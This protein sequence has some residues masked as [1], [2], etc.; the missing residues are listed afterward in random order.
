MFKFLL[1][2]FVDIV[3]PVIFSTQ[4]ACDVMS[5]KYVVQQFLHSLQKNLFSSINDFF[6]RPWFLLEKIRAMSMCILITKL[7]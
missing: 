1:T 4:I 7:I 2:F 3:T 6:C 5:A